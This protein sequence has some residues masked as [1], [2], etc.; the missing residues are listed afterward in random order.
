MTGA[1]NPRSLLSLQAQGSLKEHLA[2][3]VSDILSASSGAPAP[4]MARARQE[5]SLSRSPVPPTKNNPSKIGI[6]FCVLQFRRCDHSAT[7][8]LVAQS[9]V[10]TST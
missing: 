6:V 3:W 9:V 4:E 2:I 7:L 1:S 10:S 8:H 5:C